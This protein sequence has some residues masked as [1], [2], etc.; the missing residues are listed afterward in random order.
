[1][2]SH[3]SGALLC[4]VGCSCAPATLCAPVDTVLPS[5]AMGGQCAAS[6]LHL[7]GLHA[8]RLLTHTL[9]PPLLRHSGAHAPRPRPGEAACRSADAHSAYDAASVSD[10]DCAASPRG[11][12]VETTLRGPRP[13]TGFQRPRRCYMF[14][15]E[16]RGF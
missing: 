1:M 12:A 8:S 2:L 7:S 3:A 16:N 5:P 10:A 11:A 15:F 14:L 9:P 6:L 13:S 4:T